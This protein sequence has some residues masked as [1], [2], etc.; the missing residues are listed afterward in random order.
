MM[1]PDAQVERQGISDNQRHLDA[2]VPSWEELTRLHEDHAKFLS[3]VDKEL[4]LGDVVLQE[5]VAHFE[6]RGPDFILLLRE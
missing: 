6:V 3:V 1:C 5:E 4:L 2:D